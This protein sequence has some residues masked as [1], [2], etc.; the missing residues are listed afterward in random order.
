MV[1]Q[2]EGYPTTYSWISWLILKCMVCHIHNGA[3]FCGTIKTRG[4]NPVFETIDVLFWSYLAEQPAGHPLH[5][6]HCLLVSSPD[7]DFSEIN[8]LN[9]CEQSAL[10]SLVASMAFLLSPTKTR[11]WALTFPLYVYVP[12]KWRRLTKKLRSNLSSGSMWV[13]DPAAGWG[14]GQE[15]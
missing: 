13:T 8:K 3:L 9:H 14:R 10:N 1:A 7:A 2:G 5:Q 15:T 6:S 4:C 12:R 11:A